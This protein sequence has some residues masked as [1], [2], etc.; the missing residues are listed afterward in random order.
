M[1]FEYVDDKPATKFEYADEH[2]KMRG[3]GEHVA[4]VG[5]NATKELAG[6]QSA[7]VN[8]PK[9][10]FALGAE[11]GRIV[12]DNKSVIDPYRGI[13]ELGRQAIVEPIKGT[14]KAVVQM[15]KDFVKPFIHP[16]KSFEESP[17]NTVATLLPIGK[18]GVETGQMGIKALSGLGR[19]T[20]ALNKVVKA[21]AKDSTEKPMFTTVF[22][23]GELRVRPAIGFRPAAAMK[24]GGEVPGEA[25][26]IT[27]PQ[28]VEGEAAIA[29][30]A[31][32]SIGFDTDSI[33][34]SPE[35][36]L[37][38][39]V[40]RDLIKQSIDTKKPL[41]SIGGYNVHK[42]AMRAKLL[43]DEAARIFDEFS[44]MT[45]ETH[46]QRV[47]KAIDDVFGK[48]SPM[49]NMSKIKEHYAA[50]A[51]PAYE[52]AMKFGP[53]QISDGLKDIL[54]PYIKS[55]RRS[56]IGWEIQGLPDD[57]IK[58][59]DAVKR[60]FDR[61]IAQHNAK[62]GGAQF[63]RSLTILKERMLKE[64]DKQA[65]LYK[66]A[67]AIAGDDLSMMEAQEKAKA[68][69]RNER[70][71]NLKAAVE[72]MTSPQKDAFMVGLRDVLHE[73]IENSSKAGGNVSKLVFGSS[74]NYALRLKLKQ[75]LP[76][77]EYAKLMT[78]VDDLV[79][80]GENVYKL[81]GGSQSAEKGSIAIR[82]LDPFHI[83]KKLAIKVGKK[84]IG[85]MYN[86]RFEN[87]AR[88]VTNPDYLGQQISIKD[89][90]EKGAKK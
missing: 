3:A 67:R 41:L 70:P 59:L 83:A 46:P 30:T 11:M 32:E 5:K 48:V 25:P 18:L 58:V 20:G 50:M 71:E 29:P 14:P 90:V 56:D 53:V 81:M 39:N 43:N 66:E 10:P 1:P 73:K 31:K 49:D 84:T 68:M 23:N 87:V 36:E 34:I 9:Y 27:K 38:S 4:N 40:Q 78:Q 33:E 52:E 2:S 85:K 54:K 82:S 80:E 75:I 55:V 13:K 60:S 26:K 7:L 8:L 37:N 57:H 61:D 22:E 47:S 77:E 21:A 62:E 17:V 45:M 42:Q 64:V 65:P 35:S 69:L 19:E 51:T 63:A 74:D 12:Y 44:Q 89:L 15:A 24:A 86:Q 6:I 28:M 88:L 79:K 16:I 72:A 76:K